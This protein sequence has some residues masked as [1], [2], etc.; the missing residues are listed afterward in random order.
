MEVD[1]NT[2]KFI[3]LEY[4]R[5]NLSHVALYDPYPCCVNMLT[6][7]GLIA[8]YPSGTVKKMLMAHFD[9][10]DS[11]EEY[12]KNEKFFNG[13][14]TYRPYEHNAETG[15]I[16]SETFD[17]RL[18]KNKEVVERDLE[19]SVHLLGYHI[20]KKFESFGELVIV[21]QQNIQYAECSENELSQIS[22]FYHI[23]KTDN[24]E[25]I[26][27]NGLVPKDGSEMFKYPSRIY[28]FGD[29]VIRNIQYVIRTLAIKDERN[30]RDFIDYSLISIRPS[31][32]N[33]DGRILLFKD[34]NYTTQKA[35]FCID[36]ISPV[37]LKE[38]ARYR[39]FRDNT[40]RQIL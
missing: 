35:Y 7:E 15:G 16:S 5:K 39:L 40:I 22:S 12:E 14:L 11:R 28:I 6:N 31:I 37:F 4:E 27:K 18:L 21:I 24:I 9:L 25:K 19:K 26:M 38:E 29:E 10:T 3:D 36:N 33:G 32:F 34:D 13:Y 1:K 8:T 30:G 2:Y 20:S 17:V 23:T